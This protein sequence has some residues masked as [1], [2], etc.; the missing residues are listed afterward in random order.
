L[1]GGAKEISGGAFALPPP[2]VYLDSTLPS[3]YTVNSKMM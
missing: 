2:E 3:A 1:S